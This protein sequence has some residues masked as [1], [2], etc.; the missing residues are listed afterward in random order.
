M[1]VKSTG[2][3][4]LNTDIVGE[5]G[6]EKPHSLSEYYRGGGLVPNK[7]ANGSIPLTGSGQPIAL[8]KFYGATK[9]ITLSFK[10]Y[11]GGGAGGSG[12]EDG[13][14]GTTSRG[15][16]GGN[17]GIMLKSQFD[18][19]SP[20]GTPPKNPALSR[21]LGT[22]AKAG[23]QGG[24]S[25]AFTNAN[26]TAG[27]ASDFGA[28]GAAGPRNAAGGSPVWGRWASGGGGGGGDE[29]SGDNYFLIFNQGGGDAAGAAGEGGSASSFITG[30]LDIDVNVD[31]VVACGH[32]GFPDVAVGNHDGGYGNPGYVEFTLDTV[33]GTTYTFDAADKVP[34]GANADRYKT[35]YFGFR[36]NQAGVPEFFD[37]P[38]A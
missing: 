24:L 34:S 23:A 27:G 37:L 25:G 3:L 17:S 8:S 35:Y 2:S 38:S 9:I 10:I 4:S 28:G 30:T 7:N 20:G 21:F 11:G 16:V 32:G 19:I 15:G 6:G 12:F 33:P 26:A 1:P 22:A 18:T 36:L 31:Y 5:F 29:G 14:F 13:G